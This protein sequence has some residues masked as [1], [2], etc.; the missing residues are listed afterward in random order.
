MFTRTTNSFATALVVA[1]LAAPG[2]GKPK[3]ETTP[4]TDNKPVEAPRSPTS[5]RGSTRI[6]RR[7]PSR[8]RSSSPTCR[9]SRPRTAS[10]STSSRTT[11]S[12]WS[13]PSS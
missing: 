4:P 7:R 6:R 1:A 10:R 2:C 13:R 12:R 8:V 3:G 9:R 5:P 11:R